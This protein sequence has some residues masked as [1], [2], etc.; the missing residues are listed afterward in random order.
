MSDKNS[1][2]PL[3]NHWADLAAAKLLRSRPENS[4][5]TVASGITPS[6]YVHIGNFRE[7]ITVDLVARSLRDSGQKVR[8]IY[9]WDDFDT[10]R[11][12]PKNIENA[13]D[14]EQHLRKPIRKVPDPF[15]TSSSYAAH[16]IEKFE[17]ELKQLG[18]SPEFIYQSEKYEAG[19]YHAEIEKT[20]AAK[21]EIRASLNAHRSSPLKEKWLPTAVYCEKCFKD[22]MEYETYEQSPSHEKLYSYKCTHCHHEAKT[23]VS[24][25]AYLK[26][27]WRSDWPMRWAYEKVDFE[28]GG[29]DHSSEGGSY[30]TAK[31]IVAKVFS[32][33]APE[34]LQYDFVSLKGLDGKM[35]SSSGNVITLGEA[36]RVYDSTVLRYLFVKQKPNHDFSIAFDEDVIKTYEEFDKLEAKYFDLKQADEKT[37]NKNRSLSRIYELSQ[38]FLEKMPKSKPT[39]IPFRELANRIQLCDGDLERVKTKFYEDDLRDNFS[40]E[41]FY[42]RAQLC[43]NWLE[44]SAPESFVYK[45]RTSPDSNLDLSPI[46][47]KSMDLLKSWLKNLDTNSKS[48]KEINE[49]LYAEVIHV[50]EIEPKDFFKAFYLKIFSRDE[51]PKVPNILK[52]V[53]KSQ[54]LTLL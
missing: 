46:Q 23:P 39:R 15:G 50:I 38:A 8:F 21:E 31:E 13:S 48:E 49:L 18:I 2:K 43:K 24:E 54:L 16:F 28:P 22:E 7:V 27:A 17:S 34:Y 10:F 32:H 51:G 40:K 29:K 3:S 14:F 20:L 33:P 4:L 5:Y 42:Q 45:I 37:Q 6:G 41:A 25:T 36:C 44:F 11:K 47:I 53:D 9:S 12:V 30:D 1:A 19:D 35:S 52:E 26:L